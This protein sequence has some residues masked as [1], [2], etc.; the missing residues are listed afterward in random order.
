MSNII[1]YGATNQLTVSL[2]G[3]TIASV[4]GD[5]NLRGA[6][7]FPANVIAKING[8]TV[9]STYVIGAGQIVDVEVQAQQKAAGCNITLRYGATNELRVSVPEHTTIKTV[10]TNPSYKAALGYGSNVV[11][12][13]NGASVRDDV[14]ETDGLTVEIEVQA[15]QKAAV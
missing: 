12:K 10:L 6:L 9:P 15:Q 14:F 4:L 1:R 8:S 5:A 3:R 13:I 7:G 11:A 2:A